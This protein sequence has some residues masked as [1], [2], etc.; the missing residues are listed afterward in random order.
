MA[1]FNS[2]FRK[3]KKATIQSK[4]ERNFDR[5][6]ILIGKGSEGKS[7]LGNLL[8][9]YKL[10]K[11]HKMVDAYGLTCKVQS[12]D[13][14]IES[15]EVYDYDEFPN[16]M[17]NFQVLDQPGLNDHNF[18]QKNYCNF[19]KECI[20]EAKAEMSASFLILI[21]LNSKYFTSEE[22]LTILNLAEILSDSAYS[23]F[24]NAIV[25]FTH[26]DKVVEDMNQDRLEEELQ[27]KLKTENY[28]SVQDLIDLVDGRYIFVNAVDTNTINR[29]NILKTLFQLTIPNLNVYILGNNAF[30]GNELKVLFGESEETKCFG[31]R[32]LKYDVEYHFIPDLN[33][34][35]K[36]EKK[37]LEEYTIDALNKLS[38]I[39]K[40][41]SAMVLLI[42]LEEL[43][44]ENMYNLILNLPKTYNLG[45]EQKKD[46]W[47]YACIVF[48]L[49]ADSEE[50]VK[51]NIENNTLLRKLSI[52][53][54]YKY[55][56][57]TNRTSPEEC[58]RKLTDLARRVKQD[59]EGKSYTD[60]VVLG[61]MNR[62]IEGSTKLINSNNKEQMG[63]G[64]QNSE[65]R[66]EVPFYQGGPNDRVLV[67]A[68]KFFW[69]KESISPQIGHY[70]LK[71]LSPDLAEEF[72][73]KYPYEGKKIP[74]EEYSVFCLQELKKM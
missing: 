6:F 31:R 24:T 57:V 61:G 71:N 39:S 16:E 22:L 11:E 5:S 14:S 58:S 44:N 42:S 63:A 65:V 50:C 66:K 27:A 59:T 52:K 21:S 47:N 33:L 13:C 64:I 37:D 7:T 60:S 20:A 3:P 32:L 73:K 43:F 69:D 17:L 41:I 18:T 49:P 55:T 74:T 30:K 26:A 1:S 51:R 53:I 34:F 25:M 15:C 56:W 29:N 4:E 38:G 67:H 46:F 72:R 48:K 9:G 40:G 70:I 2:L 68:N 8:L 19:L 36:F 62:I 54:N 12:G 28:G 45:K 23:F 10:F 35:R